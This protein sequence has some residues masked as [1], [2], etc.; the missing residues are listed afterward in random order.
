MSK[1]WEISIYGK[2]IV[3]KPKATMLGWDLRR[4]TAKVIPELSDALNIFK[5]IKSFEIDYIGAEN[6]VQCHKNS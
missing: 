3:F 2:L 1:Y 4:S 6:I 5:R